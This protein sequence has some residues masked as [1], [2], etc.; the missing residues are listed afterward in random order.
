MKDVL[1]NPVNL[2]Y[3]CIVSPYQNALRPFSGTNA[4]STYA[5]DCLHSVISRFE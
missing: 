2:L 5:A 1:A 3:V 4:D